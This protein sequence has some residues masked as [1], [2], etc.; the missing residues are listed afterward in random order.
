MILVDP[1][2]PCSFSPKVGRLGLEKKSR[3]FTVQKA[4]IL[5]VTVSSSSSLLSMLPFV[6]TVLFVPFFNGF[7]RLFSC[8]TQFV[9]VNSS[10]LSLL[11]D[12]ET[13]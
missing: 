10:S 1:L 9:V 7:K 12:D 2:P 11:I 8:L 3:P 5:S 4:A 13:S 6:F